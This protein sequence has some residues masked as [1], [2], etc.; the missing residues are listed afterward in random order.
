MS[1]Y[2]CDGPDN[3]KPE[4]TTN[5]LEAPPERLPDKEGQETCNDLDVQ[6]L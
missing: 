3:H 6:K 2:S 4:T 5:R 1:D